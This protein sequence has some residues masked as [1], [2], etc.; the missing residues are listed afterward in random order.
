[1]ENPVITGI[2]I[3]FTIKAIR[4][5]NRLLL[6]AAPFPAVMKLNIFLTALT[7]SFA[8]SPEVLKSGSA[9]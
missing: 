8:R 3:S 6:T 7:W 1:M 9:M 4:T 2:S 5:R